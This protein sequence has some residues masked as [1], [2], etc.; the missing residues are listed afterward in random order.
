MKLST[1]VFSGLLISSHL[2]ISTS[3]HG[4]YYNELKALKKAPETKALFDEEAHGG[5]SA[6]QRDITIYKELTFFQRWVRSDFLGLDVIIVTPATMPRLYAYVETVCQKAEIVMPTIFVTR[7][8][9]FF[10]AFAQ[11]LL[12]STGGIVVGQQLLHDVSD[13]ELEAVVAHEIG[14]IMHNH[15]NK[16]MCLSIFKW[17]IYDRLCNFFIQLPANWTG[18]DLGKATLKSIVAYNIASLVPSLIINKRFEK[19][20]DAFACECGK[21]DGIIKFFERLEQKWQSREG[22]FDV[23]YDLL[24]QNKADII[25]IGYSFLALR[26]YMARSGHAVLK[27]FR[28]LYHDTFLGAHPSNQARIDAAKEYL[29]E[30]QA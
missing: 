29:A 9:G 18:T 5:L 14:H 8:E 1:I 19:E 2:I 25:G 30:Q 3:N 26:Y 6:I 24:Q 23:T 15:V 11:K 21:S 4:V 13:E 27:A 28:S 7:K 20:A 16:M 10:N 22:E 17:I 12:V